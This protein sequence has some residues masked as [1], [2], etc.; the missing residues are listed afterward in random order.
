MAAGTTPVEEAE[1]RTARPKERRTPADVGFGILAYGM[2]GLIP[3]YFKTVAQVAPLEVLGHRVVWS[4]VVLSLLTCTLGRWSEVWRYVRNARVM[5]ILCLGSL[6]IAANWLTF[7][8]AVLSG[9]VLQA[10]LGYF[11]G[12]LANVLLGTLLFR[13][14]L[15][16]L[17]KISVLVA[18]AGVV[19]MT[20]RVGSLPWIALVLATTGA[21]HSV[22]RKL[23]PTDG[24]MSLVLET[25][26][27]MPV[28]AAFLVGL[29]VTNHATGNTLPLFPLLM[30]GGPVTVTPF[31]CFGRA[32]RRLPLTTMG[33]LLYLLPTLQFFLAVVLFREPFSLTQLAAFACI[34]TAIVL[35]ATDA[36]LTLRRNQSPSE[37]PL[38]LDPE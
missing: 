7:I 15:R 3:L 35:Y 30:L 37:S 26:V 13:E 17:A 28:A 19:V 4:F 5:L 24:F 20:L 16:A 33:I 34:W 18:T 11:L 36:Y 14:R 1:E 2:W 10:S 29:G 12:P 27:V 21:L 6:L 22:T 25:C 38:V 9:Q 31:L 23:V 8:Y 32:V